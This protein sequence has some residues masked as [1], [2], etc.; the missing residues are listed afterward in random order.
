MQDPEKRDVVYAGTTEGLYKTLNA[1]KKFER[2]TDADVVVNAVYVDPGDSNR[3][4][5]AT[6]RGGVIKSEDGGATF[7]PSNQGIS[8]RKVAAVLVDRDN[9]ERAVRGRGERQEI[10][11]RVS[12]ERRWRALGAVGR[13]P[14][15]A[16]RVLAGETKDGRVVAG[17][18]HGIFV[19]G[20]C[21]K[22][23]R[24]GRSARGGRWSKRGG[25]GRTGAA[26]TDGSAAA[27]AALTWQPR[28]NIVNTV[29]K[30]VTET[31]MHTKVNIEKRCRRRR[32]NWRAR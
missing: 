9:P 11:R 2:M 22:S 21:G 28:N 25:G 20:R 12:L 30:T 1:G 13:R 27:P 14:R 10:W 8:E 31:H 7:T 23:G 6:D 19:L 32:S 3:V 24:R 17:T 26:A 16:R 18:S 29:T 4:L 5:L 15:W